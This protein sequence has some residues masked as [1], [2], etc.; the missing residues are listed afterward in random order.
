MPHRLPQWPK[1]HFR[2]NGPEK[3]GQI[4]GA[5]QGDLLA[6]E[7]L[8]QPLDSGQ[9]SSWISIRNIIPADSET[10]PIVAEISGKSNSSGLFV[11][12]SLDG[13]EAGGLAGRIEAEEDPHGPGK[14]KR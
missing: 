8:Y 7:R 9:Y 13:I 12:Q 4:L 10:H 6:A 14:G 3:A 11:A 1:L 5:A 2:D